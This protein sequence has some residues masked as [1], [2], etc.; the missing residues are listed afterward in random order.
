M[1]FESSSSRKESEEEMKRRLEIPE[2][3][4]ERDWR[5]KKGCAETT[6]REISS[7]EA[8]PVMSDARKSKEASSRREI[9]SAARLQ[10]WYA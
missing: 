7:E 8:N 5:A 6:P 10:A 1:K 2:S 4:C 9:S 3:C